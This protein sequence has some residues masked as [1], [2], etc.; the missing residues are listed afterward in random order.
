MIEYW[1]SDPLSVATIQG[2]SPVCNQRLPDRRRPE[3]AM[4]TSRYDLSSVHCP[5]LNTLL[6]YPMARPPLQASWLKDRPIFPSVGCLN[7]RGPDPA[8]PERIYPRCQCRHCQ[9]CG[10]TD[11]CTALHCTSRTDPIRRPLRRAWDA[12]GGDEMR[13][14]PGSARNASR[15]EG[16][17]AAGVL[18]RI[19]RL[20]MHPS[21]SNRSRVAQSEP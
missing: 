1:V 14:G 5:L 13:R 18:H 20:E 6:C 17:S 3:A 11:P 9:E 10:G 15:P 8:D 4:K 12:S 19:P 21:P 2:Y 16:E 7:V